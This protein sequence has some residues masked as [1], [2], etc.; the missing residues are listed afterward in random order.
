MT[1]VGYPRI[2]KNKKN[3]YFEKPRDIVKFYEDFKNDRD[4]SDRQK[5]LINSQYSDII[6]ETNSS[7][8]INSKIVVHSVSKYKATEK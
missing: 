5:S 7:S 3:K 8:K 1:I 2:G 4:I 6:I